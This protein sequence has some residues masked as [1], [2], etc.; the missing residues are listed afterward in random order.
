MFPALIKKLRLKNTRLVF[1]QFVISQFVIG[2]FVI[3]QFAIGKGENTLCAGMLRCKALR[4]FLLSVALAGCTPKPDISESVPTL[5]VTEREANLKAFKP[6]RALGTIAIDS[7]TQGKF[8][9]SFA[10]NVNDQGFDIKV[11]GPL[12]IQ[13]FDLSEDENGA[14]LTD[15]SGTAKADDAEQLI[16]SVLGSEVPISRMQ[17][18]VVGLPGDAGQI[19]R[20]ELGRLNSM[21]VDDGDAGSWKVDFKRYTVLENMYLPKSVLVEGD[22]VMITLSVSK[23]SR[24]APVKN[25]RLSIPGVSS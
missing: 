4:I 25:E 20:D 7:D 18:W 24:A 6:W 17:L 21:V 3:G 5:T 19:E 14:R 13:A 12:G 8:N 16:K 22:G 11:F 1:G 15:R 23:W 10:W 9:A 2:Q